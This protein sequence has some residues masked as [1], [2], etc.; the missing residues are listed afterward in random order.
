MAFLEAISSIKEFRTRSLGE[1]DK[2]Q[3]CT[4]GHAEFANTN[5]EPKIN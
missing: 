2:R 4:A 5:F 3:R 1:R